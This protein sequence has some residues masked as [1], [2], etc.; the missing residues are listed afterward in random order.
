MEY[1]VKV[2]LTRP[3]EN[4]TLKKNLVLLGL[5]LRFLENENLNWKWK[6]NLDITYYPVSVFL[7]K[8]KIEPI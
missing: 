2:K 1:E 4:T 3:P 6:L 5:R 8:I 7:K